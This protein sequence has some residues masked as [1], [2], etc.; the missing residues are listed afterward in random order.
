MGEELHLEGRA[1]LQARLPAP[2]R[3][4]LLRDGEVLAQ[5]RGSRLDWIGQRPGAYRLEATRR[6]AG[7]WRTWILSNPIYVR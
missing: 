3:I 4:R 1:V 6:Y 5:A 2:A 7:R